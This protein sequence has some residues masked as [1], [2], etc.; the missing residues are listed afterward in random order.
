M[1]FG[2]LSTQCTRFNQSGYIGMIVCE[3]RY[4]VVAQE[5]QAA[6]SH[7]HVVEE[8]VR[9]ASC[10]TRRTHS[11][12]IRV[13]SCIFL[14][15]IMSSPNTLQESQLMIGNGSARV[16]LANRLHGDSASFL[17]TLVATHAIRN[18][19]EP[20]LVGSVCTLRFPVGIGIL[21]L[22]AFAADIAQVSELYFRHFMHR[23]SDS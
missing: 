13:L 17:T 20:T 14:N 23:A 4:S 15:S 18:D 1:S 16:N 7:V 21:V 2:F 6:V 11:E 3:L 22:I 8:S 19:G 12:K 10:G 5:I 9:N